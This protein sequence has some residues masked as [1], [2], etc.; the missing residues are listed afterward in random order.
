MAKRYHHSKRKEHITARDRAVDRR[1]LEDA[2]HS[3]GDGSH[4]SRHHSPMDHTDRHLGGEEYDR[5]SK[6]D[7]E[8]L[9][10]YYPGHANL[11]QEVIMREYPMAEYADFP[12]L[13]DTIRGIDN[14]QREDKGGMRKGMGRDIKY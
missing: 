12:Y 8:M 1:N 4:H 11:P 7:M 5:H 10:E 6:S 14:R 3:R 2:H 9:K 13:D